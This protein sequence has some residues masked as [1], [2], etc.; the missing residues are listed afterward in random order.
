MLQ[1]EKE[2]IIKTHF[3][4]RL[5]RLPLLL[6]INRRYTDILIK[7]WSL[8]FCLCKLCRD[9]L[10][11]TFQR[12]IFQIIIRISNAPLR[13]V[14]PLFVLA[15]YDSNVAAYTRKSVDYFAF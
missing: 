6:F 2:Q 14:P 12:G 9:Y 7:A 4:V 3:W 11:A 8:S 10:Q 15:S 13:M 5:V 1:D